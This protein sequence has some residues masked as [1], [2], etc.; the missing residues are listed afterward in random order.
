MNDKM[1]FL[2]FFSVVLAVYGL[3]SYYVFLR[4]YQA[5]PAGGLRTAFT[6]TFW[7][8]TAT[9][10]AA[11][12]LER[13]WLSTLSDAFLWVGSFWLAALLYFFLLVLFF[14]LLR[15]LNHLLPFFPAWITG[16]WPQVKQAVLGGSLTLVMV[17]LIWGFYNAR[18]PRIRALD[19]SIP[20]EAGSRTSLQ[21]VVLSDIHLGSL[22]GKK[23]LDAMVEM[24]NGLSP[25]IILLP[26][27][28][29]DEDLEPVIRQNLGESLR[30]LSAPLGVWAV[31]GN[32]E[33]IGGAEAAHAYLEEH[34]IAVLRDSVAII[35]EAFVLVG[36]ED[37]DAA[38]F[39]AQAR[40][41]LKK[42]MQGVDT[43]LPVILM[44]HQP[45]HLEK[46]ASLGVD[47]QVSGHTHHG[48]LWPLSL[49]TRAMY[50]VSR[51]HDAIGHMQVVVSSGVGTWGPP[52]R[53][54]S[55]S[56]ILFL[57]I[58]FSR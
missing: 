48:Q 57:Q 37:R 35:D 36:R 49:I 21:A 32:H 41:P 33:H 4:G 28:I 44:D 58:S 12:F 5:L 42:L 46:A 30:Q 31:M 20:K 27:D 13:V 40:K 10:I 47:L 50:Q 17:L 52:V 26:G 45:F 25:D 29:L 38:R 24:A 16:S 22:I 19:L 14:D 54:G 56:E 1:A 53:V 2:V 6:W 18:H 51:G 55:R 23:Q 39:G 34:G 9:Y 3:G 7:A 11:R 8:L 15:L 43:R